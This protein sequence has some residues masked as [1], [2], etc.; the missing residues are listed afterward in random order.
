M[1]HAYV[2]LISNLLWILENILYVPKL[3]RAL[4]TINSDKRIKLIFDI[5]AN[6][7]QSL[8]LFTGIYPE[9]TFHCFEPLPAVFRKLRN[10]R[11]ATGNILINSAV[12]MENCSLVLHMSVMDETSTFILPNNNSKYNRLKMLVLGTSSINMYKPI[13]V[14]VVTLD[15]YCDSNFIEEI[16]LLK[17]DTEGYE[18]EVLQGSRKLLAQSKY[19]TFYLKD[20]KTT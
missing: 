15:S 18:L 13:N 1:K 9:A 2:R 19:K 3:K 10:S 5:G 4:G 6:R 11:N 12:G 20:T 14:N 8:N 7:G 16:F 17:I